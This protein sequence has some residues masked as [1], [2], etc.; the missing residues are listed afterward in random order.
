MLSSKLH[1]HEVS[2]SKSFHVS[3]SP[4]PVGLAEREIGVLSPNNQ[5]QL[6]TL[7]VQKDV[8]PYASC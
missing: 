1:C 7:H 5:H 6:R 3:S 8:L 2:S 4:A